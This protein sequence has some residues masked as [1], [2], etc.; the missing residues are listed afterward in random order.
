MLTKVLGSPTL[1]KVVMRSIGP[2]FYAL[3][4][5]FLVLYLKSID[6]SK[7]AHIELNWWYLGIA[8]LLALATR[9]LGTFT[10]F[11]ILKSL[12]ATDLHLQKQLIYVYAKAWMG[13]Y[14]PGTAPWIL[15]KIY[16]A[17][18]HGVSKQKLAI[19]S[20]LEGGLQIVTMLVFSLALLVFDK[21]LDVIGVEFKFLIIAVALIGMIVL[22]PPVFNRLIGT[23]YRVLKRKTVANEHLSTVET[24]VK[25]FSLYLLD[26]LLNG[27]SL[28]F[29]AKGIDPSLAYSNIAFAMGAA[30]LAGAASM[31]AVFAPSGL[32]VREGIQLVLFS[33]LMPKELALAVTII[34]RLWS[35]GMDVVF[36][37]LSKLIA[38]KNNNRPVVAEK[39]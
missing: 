12:G 13:R 6:F 5:I 34:T 39:A 1:R 3:L 33:T 37:G 26:A 25:G 28:F 36:F 21:R 24:L 19:S 38:G 27:L 18:Q 10:W 15:G 31:L 11:T 22:L 8:S 4:I 30:S 14:I 17:S 7:L 9:Y 20:I 2:I 16:F 35:V 29:I 32:G 23:I